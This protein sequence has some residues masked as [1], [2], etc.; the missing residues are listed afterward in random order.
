[1]VYIALHI[2]QYTRI[3]YVLT[4]IPVCCYVLIKDSFPSCFNFTYLTF[5]IFL[6]F[7]VKV[8]NHY[9]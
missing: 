3:N 5:L 4:A 1:M 9:L 6:I 8:T 7:K 2:N